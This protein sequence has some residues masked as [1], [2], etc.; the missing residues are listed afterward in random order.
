MCPLES[1][2]TPMPSPRYR[3]GGSL[4]KSGADS[5]GISGTPRAFALALSCAG[6]SPSAGVG[7]GVWANWGIAQASAAHSRQVLISISLL[8]GF[9]Q[10]TPSGHGNGYNGAHEALR[11]DA[12]VGGG[13]MG[14]NGKFVLRRDKVTAERP[15]RVL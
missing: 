13:A 11:L 7:A 8:M 1:V 6:V 5:N 4:R 12:A 3:F 2:A 15:G 9:R 14:A 10:Y